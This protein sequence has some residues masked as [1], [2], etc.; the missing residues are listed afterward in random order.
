MFDDWEMYDA[1]KIQHFWKTTQIWLIVDLII[2]FNPVFIGDFNIPT[3]AST[4]D[5]IVVVWYFEKIWAQ[6]W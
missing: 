5:G 3:E 2:I 4:C 1:Q 6:I